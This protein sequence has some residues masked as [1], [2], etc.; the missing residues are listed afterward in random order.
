MKTHLSA[1]LFLLLPAVLLSQNQDPFLSGKAE[2]V[3]GNYNNAI[4][5]FTSGLSTDKAS[6]DLLL[7]LGQSYYEISDYHKAIHYFILADEKKKNISSLWLAKAYALSG[8]YDSS[9]INLSAH[10]SSPYKVPESVIKLD[11]AFRNIENSLSWKDLWKQ[12]W[13]DEF[14][15]LLSEISYLSNHKEYIEALDLIDQ[16]IAKYTRRHQ[17]YAAR[18]KVFLALGNFN[19]AVSAYS[20]AIEISG[21][22]CDYYIE[23]ARAYSLLKKYDLAVSD[24]TRA[25]NMQP[26]HFN[27]YIERSRLYNNLSKYEPAINDISFYLSFFPDDVEA[28]YECGQIYYNKGNYL[29][30]IE[31]FNKCLSIDQSKTYFYNARGAA[32]LKTRTFKFAMQ[33]FGMALDLDPG[34]S[35]AYFN[36]GMARFYLNDTEGACYD[37]QKAAR[38][39]SKEA[40]EMINSHCQSQK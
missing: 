13:Y 35:E 23:R 20:Q 32:Y 27:L 11:P 40:I 19:S 36:K 8:Q 5:V 21:T 28:M 24:L 6:A 39:G 22:Q 3:K 12:E 2:M 30:S 29:K 31:W 37:W 26:D 1:I 14:E 10:L 34:N 16:N 15:N 38:L 4:R 33:D 25:L 9:I 17:M 7:N 18:G